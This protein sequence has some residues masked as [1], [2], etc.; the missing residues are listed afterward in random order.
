MQH[1]TH[2]RRRGAVAIR[3][4]PP[5]QAYLLAAALLLALVCAS[6]AFGQSAAPA[7]PAAT[8]AGNGVIRPP[9]QVDPGM[10]VASP[11]P[12]A[13]LPTPIVPP[14]GTAGGNPSV[15]PK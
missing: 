2:P 9:A 15:Q 11:V 7:P 10:K 12:A 1:V 8:D 4:A 6:A 13:A 3:S 14:P 5:G